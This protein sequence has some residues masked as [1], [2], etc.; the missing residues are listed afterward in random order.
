MR[1]WLLLLVG[2]WL[3]AC[4][5]GPEIRTDVAFGTDF[6]RFH[7]FGF[8]S[9]PDG[10]DGAFTTL[11]AQRL[12]AAITRQMQARGYVLEEARPDL[13]V[14]V[15]AGAQDRLRVVPRPLPYGGWGFNRDVYGGW[16][17]G[18]AGT[19]DTIQPF[20]EATLNI[21][22]ID[23]E[24]RQM[25]WQGVARWQSADQFIA[26]SEAQV[27]ATVDAIF[28]QFPFRAGEAKKLGGTGG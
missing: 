9:R 6:S 27:N 28:A 8:E 5:T 21:D 2:P 18:W 7:T 15:S 22:L 17:W 14:N 4:A 1:L 19:V 16:P 26:P 23:E 11:T 3:A 25:V 24:H 10:D 13:S 12:Q 20:V